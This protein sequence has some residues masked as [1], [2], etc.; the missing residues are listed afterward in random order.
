MRN[1]LIVVS[2]DAL[3]YEDLE[4]LRSKPGYAHL[5][6]NCAMVKR[7]RSIYP[8]L[9]YPCHATMATGCFPEKH[10]VLN[11]LR[12]EPGVVSP[13]W[14]WYHDAYHCRDIVDACKEA[15]LTT[16]CIGWPTMGN[17]PNVDYLV[18][19]I[20]ATK[21]VTPEEFRRDYLL[22][23]T[24]EALWEAVGAPN[25][26]YRTQLRSPTHFNTAVCRDIIRLYAPDLVLL[27]IGEPDHHRHMY[28]VFAPEVNQAL[29]ICAWA[30]EQL[31]GAIA[32]SGFA[33]RT[34][35]VITADHGQLDTTRICSPNALFAQAG[36]LTV[37]GDRVTDWR[38]WSHQTGMCAEI[39][40]R[41]SGD[42]PLVQ[43][44][45]EENLPGFRVYTRQEAA[46][47][48]F[49]GPF[50]LVLETDG[51]TAFSNRWT[52]PVLSAHEERKQGSH[53][54]HPDKGPRPPLLAMG[55]AFRKGAVLEQ[56]NLVDGAPTW[57][58][59][60]GAELP[61]AQGRVLTELLTSS[62]C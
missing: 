57:A 44:L 17:H 40:V 43:S 33:D 51:V 21:A 53:G 34:N 19:E 47:E 48:G 8:T 1:K 58:A 10:G 18:G 25:V 62:G 14:L 30:L 7:V 37:E 29:D 20:A 61:D 2:V 35:L 42:I 23:G 22:T 46:Q 52:G 16:A 31:L 5:L 39:Y 49:D 13:P 26:H 11:N 38:A 12:M 4:Y 27:H 15:G 56:A 3:L 41:E 55:P 59:V 36:L 60:L 28:G 50:A 45:L 54:F 9:T 6:K 32:E 24:T